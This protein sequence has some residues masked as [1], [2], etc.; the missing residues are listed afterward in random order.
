MAPL[1]PT[2]IVLFRRLSDAERRRPCRHSPVIRI[3]E[4]PISEAIVC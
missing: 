4:N 2:K 3:T 1:S